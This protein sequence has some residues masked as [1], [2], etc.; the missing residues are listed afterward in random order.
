MFVEI[1]ENLSRMWS[2]EIVRSQFL[3][4]SLS[5]SLSRACIPDTDKYIAKFEGLQWHSNNLYPSRSPRQIVQKCSLRGRTFW[6]SLCKFLVHARTM[7][8]EQSH[9]TPDVHDSHSFRSD[10]WSQSCDRASG[11]WSFYSSSVLL[12]VK[13]GIRK[14]HEDIFIVL[15]SLYLGVNH[16]RDNN[17]HRKQ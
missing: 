6:S 8:R 1:A 16:R 11:V 15:F 2:S 5:L 12:I 14:F 9:Y 7:S 4:L 17:N 3:S 10:P 13:A